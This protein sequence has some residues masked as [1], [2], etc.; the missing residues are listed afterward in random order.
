[1]G[2]AS[3]WCLECICLSASKPVQ[4]FVVKGCNLLC[5]DFLRKP[6]LGI[7][8]TFMLKNVFFENVYN[9]HQGRKSIYSIKSVDLFSNSAIC[10]GWLDKFPSLIKS[11]PINDELP[12]SSGILLFKTSRLI[13][14]WDFQSVQTPQQ[15][16]NNPGILSRGRRKKLKRKRPHRWEWEFHCGKFFPMPIRMTE[17]DV[18]FRWEFIPWSG[19][20][21]R[22]CCPQIVSVTGDK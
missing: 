8:L 12:S 9:P 14:P 13:N 17:R 19:L 20:F 7:S 4:P 10:Y 16:K 2:I 5:K 21:C 22:C 1:M 3:V 11:I 6:C 18:P 15:L